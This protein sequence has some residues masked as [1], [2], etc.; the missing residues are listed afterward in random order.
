MVTNSFGNRNFMQPMGRLSMH[1]LFGWMTGRMDRGRMTGRTNLREA[2]L[3]G[4]RGGSLS[5]SLS[6]SIRT[7]VHYMTLQK[8]FHR[9]SGV[10]S[11][12]HCSYWAESGEVSSSNFRGGFWAKVSQHSPAHHPSTGC[13]N[14]GF[15]QIIDDL[16]GFRGDTH[17]GAREGGR[18]PGCLPGGVHT[19]T[20]PYGLWLT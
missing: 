11:Y 6:L 10:N 13:L 5:L 1:V 12:W 3:S 4:F 18:E 20:E 8:Y 17:T 15:H 19:W 14:T 9:P 7:E 16:S 2:S